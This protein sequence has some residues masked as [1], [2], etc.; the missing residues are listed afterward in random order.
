MNNIRKL[1][2]DGEIIHLTGTASS[3]TIVRKT[4]DLINNY[5]G[6]NLREIHTHLSNSDFLRKLSLMRKELNSSEFRE[7]S[8]KI[9]DDLGFDHELYAIDQVRLRAIVPNAHNINAARAVYFAHRDT[10]YG[11][12]QSQINCWIPL[13][14]ID[15][16]EGFDIF[17]N[18]FSKAVENDSILFDYD[19]FRDTVGWQ[20]CKESSKKYVYPSLIGEINKEKIVPIFGKQGSIHLFSAAHLH[21]TKC[22]IGTKVRFSLDFRFVNVFDDNQGVGAP[23]V[24]NQSQG[25][26]IKDY[27]HF[28]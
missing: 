12:S 6:G 13:H 1:L 26:A 18:Y 8:W 17:A 4:H 7:I 27:F 15:P 19:K 3:R 10:W 28:K 14:D 22:I 21:Q 9:L 25:A 24:D 16:N 23:N 11:N 20:S 2:Y 5:F